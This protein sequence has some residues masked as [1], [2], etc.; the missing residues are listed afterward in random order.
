MTYSSDKEKAE[1]PTTRCMTLKRKIQELG[2]LEL[3]VPVMVQAGKPNMHIVLTKKVKSTL[4]SR[5]NEPSRDQT[6]WTISRSTGT[7]ILHHQEWIF[8]IRQH[9]NLLYVSFVFSLKTI[10]DY[11]YGL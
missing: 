10:L 6:K 4:G 5:T 1:Y 8:K 11:C 3:E 9:F 2:H 7:W